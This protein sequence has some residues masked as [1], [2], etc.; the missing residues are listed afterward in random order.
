MNEERPEQ[1][2]LSAA[3]SSFSIV[4]LAGCTSIE[5]ARAREREGWGR[6]RWGL[7]RERK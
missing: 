4:A 6:E 5:R 7:G 1:I 3:K 2:P